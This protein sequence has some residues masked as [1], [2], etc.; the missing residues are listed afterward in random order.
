M[1]PEGVLIYWKTLLE[2][3]D[4]LY[5]PRKPFIMTKMLLSLA[6]V[7]AAVVSNAAPA[8]PASQLKLERAKASPEASQEFGS[9]SIGHL[10]TTNNNVLRKG[11]VSVGTL[12]AG[13]GV[14]DKLTVG[15]SPFVLM[16]F[17]MYNFLARAAQDVSKNER[18][19]FEFEYF[20]TFETGEGERSSRYDF[21]MEAWS[22][23]ITYSH[24]LLNWYRANLTGS[25]FY[26]ID[27]TW[28]FSLRMDPANTDRYACNLTSLHEI[29]LSRNIFIN[30]EGGFWGLNYTYPYYHAGA[31]LN[32]QNDRFL[33]GIGASTTFSPS[34]PEEKARSFA[35]YD[36]RQSVHPELQMQA[37]F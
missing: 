37:F 18:I 1:A 7:F 22:S 32:L 4:P 17:N 2:D 28:P 8:A 23:K 27:E 26:Y 34:F 3:L 14:T 33:F 30:L 31:T 36:S 15:T 20:K 11:E 29:R 25:F 19:G 13:V 16:A 5:R 6:V 10:V 9:R 24:R 35:G 12:Y 21:Q